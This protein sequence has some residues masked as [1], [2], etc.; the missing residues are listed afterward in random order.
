[1]RGIDVSHH[2]GEIDWSRVATS[3]IRFT[4]IKATEGSEFR[5]PAFDRNW[6]DA[7]VSGLM[8]GGYHFFLLEVSGAEQARNFMAAVPV[9]ETALPPAIDLEFSGYNKTNR[10]PP[11]DFRRE[12]SAFWDAVA[13]RY[14]KTPVVYTTNEFREKYLS[15]MPI[16]R[17]WIREVVTRPRG[18]WTFW[19][20]SARGRI[21]GVK[22]LVDLNVF[23]GTTPHF[24][25]FQRASR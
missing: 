21:D 11:N 7:A 22:T 8:R 12:L 3:E 20:F 9:E 10:P 1:M 15:R 5:D 6:R 18:E 25:E 19:Q 23:E 4:Y 2:Q 24:A 16:E 13:A 14:G 17:L